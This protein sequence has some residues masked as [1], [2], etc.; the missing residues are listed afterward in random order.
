MDD[1]RKLIVARGYDEMAARYAAWAGETRD[2]ARDELVSELVSRLTDDARVLDLGCG[3]GDTARGLVRRF[4]VT[5]IDVSPRQIDVARRSVPEASFRVADATSVDFPP[6]S[7]DAVVALYSIS[8]IPRE[9]HVDLFRRIAGWL[10]P[11][12]WLL[13]T[14]GAD[15]APD[16]HG[17]WLG[18]PMFF[19]AWDAAT[20]RRLL[21]DSG[22][23]LV[24]DRVR[25]THEPEGDVSFLWVLA[26]RLESPTRRP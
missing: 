5:G 23:D 22:F 4:D 19:S 9:A 18:V 13:A 15:D 10:A 12:G 8:H 21:R 16:W 2:E 14:L 3:A 20:N 17:S 11:G 26:R 7:F 6:G 24:I 25:T 1:P